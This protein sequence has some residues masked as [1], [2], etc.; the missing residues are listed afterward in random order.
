M[1]GHPDWKNLHTE[2]LLSNHNCAFQLHHVTEL[3]NDSSIYRKTKTDA[4]MERKIVVF[5][6]TYTEE[7]VSSLKLFKMMT[8][9][10]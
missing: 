5:L 8:V 3:L 10:S 4:S 7:K 9:L 2:G 1:M 6:E